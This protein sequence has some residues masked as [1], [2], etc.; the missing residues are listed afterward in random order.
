MAVIS[1]LNIRRLRKLAQ[2]GNLS[3]QCWL[4]DHYGRLNSPWF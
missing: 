2:D 3:A 4:A 1:E